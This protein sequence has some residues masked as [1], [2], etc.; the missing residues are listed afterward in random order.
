MTSPTTGKPGSELP[1]TSRPPDHTADDHWDGLVDCMNLLEWDA[2]SEVV[3]QA[4]R[5]HAGTVQGKTI[6]EAGS[7]T[8]RISHR[9][10]KAGGVVT[11]LDSST[12]AIELSRQRFAGDGTGAAFHLGTVFSLPFP[13]GQFDIVWNAALLE[14]FQ[15]QEQ[16]AALAEMARVCRPGGLVM[17]LNPNA[18]ALCYRL[19]KAVIEAVTEFPYGY[20]APIRTL[21]TAAQ[22]VLRLEALP[23]YSAGFLVI[24]IGG[25]E[26]CAMAL[27]HP[28]WRGRGFLR[29]MN[30]A[31]LWLQDSPLGRFVDSVDRALSLVLGGYLLV[32]SFRRR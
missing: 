9:L 3:F 32:S 17:T 27:G 1:E 15:P 28:D 6:L 21:R 10:A 8:G 20:E 11:L 30:Q 19:G 16:A 18:R 22:Q 29:W 25:L 13:D 12:K 5:R 26:V 14:H 7:G 2:V 24:P 4:V 31:L 23:E